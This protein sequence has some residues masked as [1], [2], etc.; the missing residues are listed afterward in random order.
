MSDD[1]ERGAALDWYR[2]AAGIVASA[3]ARAT[4]EVHAHGYAASTPA[5]IEFVDEID[6]PSLGVALDT[7][8]L[9]AS[10]G[11]VGA[12]DVTR[13]GPRLFDVHVKDLRALPNAQGHTLQVGARHFR[14]TLLGEGDVRN[15]LVLD[16]LAD[17]AYD[18]WI[19]TECE[20]KW[21]T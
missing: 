11:G 7:G 10:A 19:A 5:A 12:G 14:H 8:N 20:C 9:H 4:V 16:G 1:A 21:S 13:L 3:G 2:Q 6:H 15:D 18:G 17:A